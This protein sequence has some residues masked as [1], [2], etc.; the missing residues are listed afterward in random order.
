MTRSH[1]CCSKA[2]ELPIIVK[3]TDIPPLSHLMI[4]GTEEFIGEIR[5]FR[6]NSALSRFMPDKGRTSLSWVRL[7]AG[8][9]HKVHRHPTAS[10][11]IVFEGC[12]ELIGDMNRPIVAGDIVMVPPQALHG[13]TG[14]GSS[15]FSALSVQFGGSGLFEKPQD[16]R[17][18]FHEISPGRRLE[19]LGVVQRTYVE[20]FEHNSLIALTQTDRIHHD[21]KLQD[22]LLDVL[23]IWSDHFQKLIR[24]RAASSKDPKFSALAD[25]H[26]HDELNHNQILAEMRDNRP[27]HIWD[28]ILE[29]TCAWFAERMAKASD[30]EATIIMHMV[31]ETAGDIFHKRAAEIFPGSRHFACHTN[32]D[33]D[34]ASMG[35]EVLRE[36]SREP[37]EKMACALKQ[38]WEMMNL[39]CK[40]IAELTIFKAYPDECRNRANHNALLDLRHF[41]H[42]FYL[43]LPRQHGD[44]HRFD[45]I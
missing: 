39:L 24:L 3:R 41:R 36:H 8:E 35:L 23:Q 13:F 12:G 44:K 42:E 29:S 33:Q 21:K 9:Q 19:P 4:E 38:A 16:P 22:S 1:R 30:V 31:I 45:V 37:V 17:L 28:P 25:K 20:G 40:R 10:I 5:D 34:H 7:A 2:N 27:V 43:G 14:C 26:L 32:Q 15:G 6:W 11:I 18:T